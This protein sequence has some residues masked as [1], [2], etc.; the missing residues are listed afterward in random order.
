MKFSINTFFLMYKNVN[1]FFILN[2]CVLLC[3]KFEAGEVLG[4]LI[5]A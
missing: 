2:I 1:S 5:L 4:V 3:V